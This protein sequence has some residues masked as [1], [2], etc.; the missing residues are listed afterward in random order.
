MARRARRTPAP[1]TTEELVQLALDLDLTAL[2]D[3][4][5]QLLSQAEA[6]SPSF[7]EFLL[8]AFH[9]EATVRSPPPP[10]QPQEIPP[11]GGGR[12][13]RIRLSRSP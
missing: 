13:G 3:A 12:S 4:L 11:W 9:S 2:A 5:P 7:S 6:T 10:V 8:S 1:T